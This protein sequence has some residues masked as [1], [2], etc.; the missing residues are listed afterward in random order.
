MKSYMHIGLLV[1]ESTQL[2]WHEV[3]PPES[4]SRLQNAA[5][6]LAEYHDNDLCVVT[7]SLPPTSIMRGA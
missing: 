2:T 1:L 6:L 3:I 7:G 4:L 5:C